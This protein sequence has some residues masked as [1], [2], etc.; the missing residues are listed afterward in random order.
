MSARDFI[1]DTFLPSLKE[2]I[3]D[4]AKGNKHYLRGFDDALKAITRFIE[5][6]RRQWDVAE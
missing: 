1:N 6:H 5:D 2:A 4:E 3:A